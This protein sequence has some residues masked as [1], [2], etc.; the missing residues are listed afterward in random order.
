MRYNMK[1]SKLCILTVALAIVMIGATG[2]RGFGDYTP[3]SFSSTSNLY[4]VVNTLFGTALADNAQLSSSY[5]AGVPAATIG[6]FSEE[7]RIYQVYGSASYGASFNLGN[8]LPY[9][10][11]NTALTQSLSASPISAVLAGSPLYQR[12][13]G[14]GAFSFNVRNNGAGRHYFSV[15]GAST[16][17]SEWNFIYFNVTSLVGSLMPSGYNTAYLVGYEEIL[18]G[19][20][21][22]DDAVFLILTNV[23]GGGGPGPNPSGVPEPAT[24]LLWT[25][26]GLGMAGASWRRNRM[27]NHLA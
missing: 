7:T 14:T 3:P 24:M 1:N 6:T 26:G 20:T 2:Q 8:S 12:L 17:G 4:N 19:D 18:N 10:N 5:S 21:S 25:L 13:S 27:K 16:G 9:A 11:L 15:G 23:Q 22:F